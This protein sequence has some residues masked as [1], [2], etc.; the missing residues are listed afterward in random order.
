VFLPPTAAITSNE[1][2]TSS[3][4]VHVVSAAARLESKS[5]VVGFG[6]GSNL[7]IKTI[8]PSQGFDTL[9]DDFNYTLLIALV[10]GLAVLVYILHIISAKVTLQRLW[11]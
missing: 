11:H 1:S 2:I 3:G 5:L 6:S 8:T 7:F 10:G 9:A 4:Q